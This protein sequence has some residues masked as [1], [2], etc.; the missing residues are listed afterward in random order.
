MDITDTICAIATPPGI[1]AIAVIR[2]SG[3][4]SITVCDKIFSSKNPKKKLSNQSSH[5]I[6]YGTIKDD[7]KIIDDVLISIFRAP[8]SY[9]GEDSAEISCHGSAYIQ[10]KIIELLIKKG[11][12]FA[13]PGEFTLRGFLNGKFDLSQAEAVADLIASNSKASHDLA[14]EQMRGGYSNKIKN[15]RQQLVHFASLIELELDFSE[16]NVEFANRKKLLNLLS[17][18]KTELKILIDSFSVGNVL[19][20][21]IPIAIIGKPNVG[22]STLLN[23]ILNEEKAIVS[24]IPGTTRDAVEDT[25][26]INGLSFRFIDT[27]GLRKAKDEIEY[28]GIE[29]TYE[30]INQAAIVLYVFDISETPLEEINEAIEDFKKHIVDKSKP[31]ILIGNKTDK[32]IKVPKGFKNLVE[33]E[34]VF[35]SAKRKE[36]IN[37]IAESLLKSIYT[38][39]ITDNTIVSN[40]RH[41]EALTKSLHALENI[42]QGIDKD[43]PIDLLDIDIREA[44][45]HLGEITGEITTDEILDNIFGKFCIGK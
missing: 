29:K 15:L 13:K 30:K 19:K 23:A 4:E 37:L 41:Y 18:I 11:L 43:I 32:L 7:N 31:L 22:K 35:V 8:N 42:E 14:I 16:E 45:Q 3:K 36:N 24:Q 28:M 9:T 39:N 44:L 21:G 27:A 1:G 10:Q 20:N 33:L 17:K 40:A 6:H 38:E 2:V 25:I 12:R 34:T 26:I 5:T